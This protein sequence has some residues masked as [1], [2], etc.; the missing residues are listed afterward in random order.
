MTG[1]GQ[2]FDRDLRELGTEFNRL[3]T[4]RDVL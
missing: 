4:V 3:A 2:V 1:N